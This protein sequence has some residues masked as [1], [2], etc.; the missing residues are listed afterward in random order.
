MLYDIAAGSDLPK[1]DE[2]CRQEDAALPDGPPQGLHLSGQ[3]L[4]HQIWLNEAGLRQ[5][6]PC[7]TCITDQVIQAIWALP[8]RWCVQVPGVC[9]LCVGAQV[10]LTVHTCPGSVDC[11][12]A[13]LYISVNGFIM[14]QAKQGLD[15][16]VQPLLHED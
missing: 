9:C 6:T 11:V 1:E 5:K 7:A 8:G 16:G 2:D 4:L 3:P 10:L 14:Q 15:S 13:A 12:Y